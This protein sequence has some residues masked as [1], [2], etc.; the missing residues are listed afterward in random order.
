MLKV[1]LLLDMT[2]EAL[3]QVLQQV[4]KRLTLDLTGT[5]KTQYAGESFC[6]RITVSISLLLSDIARELSLGLLLAEDL[7]HRPL[8]L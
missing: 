8:F 1:L 3:Q 5:L 2:N 4:S 7:V 6:R